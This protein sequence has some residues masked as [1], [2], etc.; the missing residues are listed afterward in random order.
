[1]STWHPKGDSNEYGLCGETYYRRTH[2]RYC[3]NAHLDEAQL[4]LF[5]Q[6]NVSEMEAEQ[7][8]KE[9]LM[10]QMNT[11]LDKLLSGIVSDEIY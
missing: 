8:K 1:M 4:M 7:K 6:K 10:L 2:R 3:D 9:S 11:L 5:L